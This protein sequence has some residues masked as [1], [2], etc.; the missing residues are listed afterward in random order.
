MAGHEIDVALQQLAYAG[1]PMDRIRE[2]VEAAAAVDPSAMGFG[3]ANAAGQGHVEVVKLMLAHGAEVT[4]DL[5]T[6]FP[7][8]NAAEGGHAEII[9]LLAGAGADPDAGRERSTDKD[10]P[11][12]DLPLFAAIRGG[13]AG[14]VTALIE[15]GADVD[16][17]SF[18]RRTPLDAARAMKKSKAAANIVALLEAAG[19]KRLSHDMLDLKGAIELNAI[20]RVAELAKRE[21]RAVLVDGLAHACSWSERADC[22]AAILAHGK[23]KLTKADLAVGLYWAA[24]RM[25][26]T[27]CT[28]RRSAT[29]RRRSSCCSPPARISVRRPSRARPRCTALP[30]TSTTRPAR[31]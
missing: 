8:V 1:G 3:L 15:A 18:G 2:L 4:D 5:G 10:K 16:K 9:A 29:S 13:H 19:A 17:P 22:V 26:T 23:T 6:S 25:A 11:D 21:K 31:S 24:A 30:R 7:L 20:A 12:G 14:A 27:R 28:P